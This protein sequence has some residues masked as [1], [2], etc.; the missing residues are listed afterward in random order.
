MIDDI[1]NPMVLGRRSGAIDYDIVPQ[2][3]ICLEDMTPCEED[4]GLRHG[5]RCEA[6][7]VTEWED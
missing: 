7:K 6:C 3:S 4:R 5:F 1:E 2:C